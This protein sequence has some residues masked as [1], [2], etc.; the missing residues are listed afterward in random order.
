MR[1]F[2]TGATGFVGG[3]AARALARRG[4]AL[5]ALV[6][7][8][9]RGA[10]LGDLPIEWIPGDLEDGAAL[11]RGC[12]G[13][14]V[15]VH[16][17]GV[18]KAK[19]P[20]DFVRGNVDGTRRLAE[21]AVSVEPSPR[22][23]VLVSSLAASGPSDGR[24]RR[25]EDPPAPVSAYGRSKREGEEALARATQGRSIET[26]VVRPPIVYGPGDRDLLLA[27]RQV[28]HGAFPVV[29]GARTLAKRFSLVH[30]EDLA[31][32]L[33]R[34]VEA[35]EAAGR[36]YFVPGPEDATFEEMTRALEAAVGRSARRIPVPDAV[37][38][39]AAWLAQTGAALLGRASIVSVD[40]LRELAQP[41][42]V[43]SGEAARRDLRWRPAIGLLEGFAATAA[44]YRAQGWL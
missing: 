12:E 16:V 43:C 19:R 36:A 29:G 20:G 26:V 4:H 13:A 6:R 28:R 38:R 22:R 7:D 44:W 40:K 42:W 32:A 31:D 14:D 17:A 27:F 1:I 30:A 8:P 5:R 2:L 24:P 35:P 33:A 9:A 10:S 41:G 11:R 3:H 18:T 21:T 39:P 25:E 23:I 15:V 34:A 37:A